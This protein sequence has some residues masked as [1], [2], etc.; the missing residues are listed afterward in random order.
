MHCR[1][2]EHENVTVEKG[3]FLDV[4]GNDIVVNNSFVNV[5]SAKDSF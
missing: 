5:S 3:I 4:S 1:S 2:C